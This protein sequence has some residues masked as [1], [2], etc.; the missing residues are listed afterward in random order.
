MARATKKN[1]VYIAY[2]SNLDRGQMACRCPGA[3]VIGTTTLRGWRLAF[4]G[5]P[6]NAHATILPDPDASTPVLLW[7]ITE[8]DE[9]A[10]DRYEGV[11]GGYYTKEYVTARVGG[12]T[13][14]DAL[15]Y[16]MSPNPYNRPHPSYV[17]TILNG[18]RQAGFYTEPLADALGYAYRHEGEEQA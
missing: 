9:A 7:T 12:Q 6:W 17:V 16:I 13:Y 8:A 5:R 2:G 14:E 1:T 11:R 10:L 18:Y 15:V 3:K 4:M